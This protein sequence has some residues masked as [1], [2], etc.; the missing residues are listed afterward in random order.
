V[1]G[2]SDAGQR[3]AT[4]RQ[5]RRL[6]FEDSQEEILGLKKE[7]ERL[8]AHNAQLQRDLDLE[9]YGIDINAA[10]LT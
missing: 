10:A 6:F 4:R 2:P 8:T 5:A 7:I 3:P 1:Q 9:R